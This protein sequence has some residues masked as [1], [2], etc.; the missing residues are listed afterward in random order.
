[1]DSGIKR[2]TWLLEMEWTVQ[3]ET[4]YTT[5]VKVIIRQKATPLI[6]ELNSTGIIP[7]LYHILSYSYSI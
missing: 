5:S 3:Y 7:G 6:Y 1:M 4:S 2:I